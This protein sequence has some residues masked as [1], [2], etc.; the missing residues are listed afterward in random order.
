VAESDAALRPLAGLA[1]AAL[2]AA[3]FGPASADYP[4]HILPVLL[5][6]F[7]DLPR[8]QAGGRSDIGDRAAE[9]DI[10]ADNFDATRVLEYVFHICLADAEASIEISTVVRLVPFSH[11]P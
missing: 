8:V 11:L 7:A 4:P 3:V 2:A 9:A 10:I 5:D 6:Q 1:L